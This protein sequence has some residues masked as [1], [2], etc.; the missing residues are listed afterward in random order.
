MKISH[1]W[2]RWT[3]FIYIGIIWPFWPKGL[4]NCAFII[5]ISIIGY[6][7]WYYFHHRW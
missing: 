7:Y 5:K 6:K 4:Y 2:Y 1:R 3:I